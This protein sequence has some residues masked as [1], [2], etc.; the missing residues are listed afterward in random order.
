MSYGKRHSNQQYALKRKKVLSTVESKLKKKAVAGKASVKSVPSSTANSAVPVPKAAPVLPAAKPPEKETSLLGTRKATVHYEGENTGLE[1]SAHVRYETE[2][3]SPL[4][5]TELVADGVQVYKRYIGPPKEEKYL[6]DNG[7]EHD[8][9]HVEVMQVLPDGKLR[10]LDVSRTDDLTI[11]P[12]PKSSMNDWHP[13]S[14]LEIWGEKGGD[15]EGL[16]KIA[17]ELVTKG[18]VGVIKKFSHGV[19][20]KFYVGFLYP[21]FSKDGKSFTM[22]VMLSEN[23]RK[24]RRWMPAERVKGGAADRE[25]GQPVIPDM[26]GGGNDEEANTGGET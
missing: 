7:K 5:K 8:K 9:S 12:V 13:Y 11:E 20:G 18:E 22:E 26:F 1:I 3:V 21:V 19:G 25:Y 2:K 10:P 6:D 15:D 17:R 24:R 16:R 4:V 23:K 14:H